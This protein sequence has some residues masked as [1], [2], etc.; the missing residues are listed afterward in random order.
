MALPVRLAAGHVTGGVSF[1]A[2]VGGL[3]SVNVFVSRA[4]TVVCE[5]GSEDFA[6]L[7]LRTPTDEA[8][9]PG[10]VS[11]DIDRRL[12][13]AEGVAVVDLLEEHSPGCSQETMST[14]LPSQ[15]VRIVLGGTTVRSG[16]GSNPGPL[17]A[18]TQRGCAA[19]TSPG[20]AS[21]R[22]RSATGWR[23]PRVGRRS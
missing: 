9:A 7:T 19:S 17:T 11:L 16:R 22:S 12:L 15:P 8:A 6:T 4:T 13:T 20:T 1:S 3:T 14:V 2:P 5:D 21:A 18:A 10:P 23:A